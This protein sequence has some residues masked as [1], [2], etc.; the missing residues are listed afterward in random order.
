MGYQRI[1]ISTLPFFLFSLVFFSS[2][3]QKEI[4]QIEGS[5][6][7]N[8]SS[9]EVKLFRQDFDKMV[10]LESLNLKENK[11]KFVFKLKDINEPTFFHLQVADERSRTI[12]LLIEP[13]ERTFLD[14]DMLNFR[15]YS[16][17]GSDG[18]LKTKM[19]NNRLS[20][21][22]KSLDSLNRLYIN[23]EN[24]AEKELLAEKYNAVIEDQRAFN[25]QFIWENPM[26][27]ASVMALYQQYGEDQYIFDRAEDIQ[28]FKVVGSSLKAMYPESEYTKGLLRDI[29]NQERILAS[30]KL[31]QFINEAES[32][33]PEISLPNTKGD[34]I[35]LS[36]LRGKVILLDF[37]AS[38]NQA[39]LLENRELLE[40]YA[41]FK[42]KGFEI[43]QVS[44]DVDKDSWLTALK[45]SEIPWISVRAENPDASL[46]VGSYNISGIPS[47]YLINK[48]FDIVGK[49]LYGK[50]LIAKLKETL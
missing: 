19:L 6:K 33:L 4:A 47:N 12:I 36:A 44:L 41:Q 22:T 14:V 43:F 26:S 5:L 31:I 17:S 23:T 32:S 25:S 21:T 10:L 45:L 9:L 50:D 15:E 24:Q 1:I 13:G 30:H 8:K 40:I 20:Q 28:L 16:V 3:K 46:I 34:T 42:G 2:C 37:W 48:E 11:S 7:N 49:N 18:S 39:S 38:V 29:A 27:R 35:R